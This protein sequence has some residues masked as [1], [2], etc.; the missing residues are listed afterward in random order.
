MTWVASIT[1]KN[2]K[3]GRGE[4]RTSAESAYMAAKY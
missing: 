3:K 4:D 1:N 2:K